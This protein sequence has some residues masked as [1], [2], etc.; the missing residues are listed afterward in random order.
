MEVK[1]QLRTLIHL[2]KLEYSVLLLSTP[3]YSCF[4]YQLIGIYLFLPVS[5]NSLQESHWFM[6]RCVLLDSY[7]CLGDWILN[8]KQSSS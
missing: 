6:H 4:D 5:L 7:V 1:S 3:C 8:N 2:F